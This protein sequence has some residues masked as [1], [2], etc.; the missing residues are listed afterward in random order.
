MHK[1]YHQNLF[2]EALTLKYLLVKLKCYFGGAMY[3]KQECLN[4]GDQKIE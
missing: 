1:G 3:V 2:A 4:N